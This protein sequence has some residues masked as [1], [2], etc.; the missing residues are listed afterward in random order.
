MKKLHQ[1]TVRGI[2]IASCW[3]KDGRV[4]A[5]DIA[6]F[7]EKRYRVVNDKTGRQL[8][9]LT[10]QQVTAEGSLAMRGDAMYIQISGFNIISKR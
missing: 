8:H 10:M 6:G 7:D 4:S 2:I 1:T 5:V 9:A 3:S